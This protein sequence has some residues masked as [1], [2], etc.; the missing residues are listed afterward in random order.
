M[1]Y[2]VCIE[3]DNNSRVEINLNE[4]SCK[5][6]DELCN[7]LRNTS[8][9]AFLKCF[10]SFK[11]FTPGGG[12]F[13]TSHFWNNANCVWEVRVFFFNRKIGGITRYNPDR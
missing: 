5:V 11:K 9:E 8:H 7:E 4:D 2:P 3:I 6:L 12:T 10:G 13:T 1:H